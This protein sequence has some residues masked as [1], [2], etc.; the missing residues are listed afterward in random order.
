M[1]QGFAYVSKFGILKKTEY[2]S[3]QQKKGLCNDGKNATNF[4]VHMKDIGYIEHDRR[5]NEQ[6]RELVL[7]QPLSIG[8]YTS[9]MMG[10]YKQGVMTDDFLHCSYGD[11]EVNHGVLLVG[12]GKVTSHDRVNGRC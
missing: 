5:T 7:Q 8:V 9:G 10:A 2:K 12:Y 1:Y 3:Y 6:L 11:R 4:S